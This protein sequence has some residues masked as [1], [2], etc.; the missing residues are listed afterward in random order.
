M[1]DNQDGPKS[2]RTQSRRIHETGVFASRWLRRKLIAVTRS[3]VGACACPMSATSISP[4][5]LRGHVPELFTWLVRNMAPYG[6]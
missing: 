1:E 6:S 5:V 4:D 2:S 3:S